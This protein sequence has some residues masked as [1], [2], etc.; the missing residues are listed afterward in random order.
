MGLNW[1]GNNRIEIEPFSGFPLPKK[2][3]QKSILLD[4]RCLL[5]PP[6]MRWRKHYRGEGGGGS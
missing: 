2:E 4:Q 3:K 6:K 1:M 5:D